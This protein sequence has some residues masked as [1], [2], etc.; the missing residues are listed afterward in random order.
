MTRML[1]LSARPGLFGAACG[2]IG[3]LVARLRALHAELRGLRAR[4][5]DLSDRNWELK[6]TEER[7]RSLLEAQGDVIVRR[8]GDHNISYANDAFCAL[9]GRSRAQL[10][11]SAFA[12]PVIA[13]GETMLAT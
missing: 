3:L 2:A 1:S 4:V 13:Q 7:T 11:G 8:D 10:V 9:A 5:E 12:L 6:E